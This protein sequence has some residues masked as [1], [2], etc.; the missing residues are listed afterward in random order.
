MVIS[1][2]THKKKGNKKPFLVREEEPREKASS[3]EFSSWVKGNLRRKAA[4]AFFLFGD[5]EETP[6]TKVGLLQTEPQ[7]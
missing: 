5:L 7:G 3:V 1:C 6:H 2:H 4:Q